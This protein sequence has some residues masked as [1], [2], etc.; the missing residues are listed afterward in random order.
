M[1]GR[2]GRD[3]TTFLGCRGGFKS[4]ERKE[5]EQRPKSD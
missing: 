3:V 2:L 4:E 1:V 5:K